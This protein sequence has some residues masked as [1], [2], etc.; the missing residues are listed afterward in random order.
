MILL[1]G[2]PFS[3]VVGALRLADLGAM[4]LGFPQAA[5]SIAGPAVRVLRSVRG[6]VLAAAAYEGTRMHE[7]TYIQTHIYTYTQAC[8]YVWHVYNIMNSE[9]SHFLAGVSR[10]SRG[11]G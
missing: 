5:K 2:D 9:T 6:L 11:C 1:L 4:D 8:T 7:H 10:F 3:H